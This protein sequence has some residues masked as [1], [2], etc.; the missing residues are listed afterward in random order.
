MSIFF[1][2]VKYFFLVRLLL[3]YCL[4]LTYSTEGGKF[5]LKC[6][7]VDIIPILLMEKLRL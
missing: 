2:K 5:H 4:I 7:E 3:V 1:Q 6:N